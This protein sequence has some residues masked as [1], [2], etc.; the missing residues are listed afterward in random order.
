MKVYAFV[1]AKGSL[2]RVANKNMRF[3]D[4]DRLFVRAMKTLL[5]CKG[6]DRV[7]LDTR[8]EGIFV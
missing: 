5:K 4:G 2:A 1:T 6:I 3:F 7:F 8:L